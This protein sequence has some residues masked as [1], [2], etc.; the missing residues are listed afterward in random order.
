MPFRDAYKKVGGD[1]DGANLPIST[2]LTHVHEG[3]I[4]NT[5]TETLQK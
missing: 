5:G 4:G 3:S 1:I 2:N